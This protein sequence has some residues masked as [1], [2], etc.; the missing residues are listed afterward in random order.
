MENVI[1]RNEIHVAVL[2]DCDNAPP[3]ILRHAVRVAA[4]FGRVVLRRGYG[5]QNSL[6]TKWKDI[7]VHH[8]F[9]PC[10][11]YQYAA[12]KNTADIAL[13]LDAQ[14]ILFDGRASTFCL[15]TS[16][17]DFSYLCR[18][19]RERGATVCVIGEQKSPKSLRN[20]CD[21]FFEWESDGDLEAVPAAIPASTHTEPAIQPIHQN[22][23]P[24]ELE[25]T[26]FVMRRRPFFVV[27]AVLLLARDR[28]DGKISL[29]ELGQYLKR[30]DPSFSPKSYGH[31]G[32]HN[33]VKAYDLLTVKQD[34]DGAI[35]VSAIPEEDDK[36]IPKTH[37][38]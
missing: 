1:T 10:L 37:D 2:A 26:P 15:V 20:A 34:K 30:T 18:K 21:Q 29:S 4:Q 11:Q 13:A 5:N 8:A 17:S 22:V 25:T 38:K 9:T 23:N 7:L 35:W 24:L 27:K 12:G 31:N 32:L 28:S 33:M 16:D 19:L 14:E 36:E 6:S 3:G